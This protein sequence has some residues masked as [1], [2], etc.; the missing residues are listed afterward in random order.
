MN[1]LSRGCPLSWDD[2]YPNKKGWEEREAGWFC[3]GAQKFCRL[4]MQYDPNPKY[5]IQCSCC[6]KLKPKT[7][8]IRKNQSRNGREGICKECKK[9]KLEEKIKNGW[10]PKQYPRPKNPPKPSKLN[11]VICQNC[12]K[13]LLRY[14][15]HLN[16]G[17]FCSK[18]CY[19]EFCSRPNATCSFCG[20]KFYRAPHKLKGKEMVFCSKKCWYDYL[21]QPN[22]VCD[23]CKKPYHR[24]KHLEEKSKGEFCSRK[25]R[26][27]WEHEKWNNSGHKK[28]KICEQWKPLTPEFY[29]VDNHTMDG[30]KGECKECVN[31]RSRERDL[32]ANAFKHA[33]RIR[34]NS[35]KSVNK[36]RRKKE[37]LSKPPIEFNLSFDEA[38][39]KLEEQKRCCYYTGR[40]LSE[41]RLA[42][43]KNNKRSNFNPSLDRLDSNK[44]YTKD[45]VVW[46]LSA[47]NFMKGELDETKFLELVSEICAHKC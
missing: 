14:G 47:I 35:C 12:G 10:V 22:Y 3:L 30:W 9:A 37:H 32:K 28:C 5:P 27:S 42:I 45:N 1:K 24:Q 16:D 4:C 7:E 8:F 13:P 18:E 23:Y 11:Q 43:D 15:Y 39:E 36:K 19:S 31:Q 25:C 38:L 34:R 17:V 6:Q 2:G 46:T 21:K 44:G 26:D 40:K 29:G 33:W 41:K 20:E